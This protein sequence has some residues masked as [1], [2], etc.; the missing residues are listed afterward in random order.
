ME[1]LAAA[2]RAGDI[3]RLTVLLRELSDIDLGGELGS[4]LFREAAV[5]G[6]AEVVEELLLAGVDPNRAWP[7]RVEPVSWFAERGAWNM[8][9]TV[10]MHNHG[11]SSWPTVPESSLRAALALART[12]LTVDPEQELRRRL[13]A[14]DDPATV[15]ERERVPAWRDG[16]DGPSAVRI[17]VH[18]ADGRE[19]RV[20]VAHRAVVTLLEDAL[21]IVT[22]ND[23]IA[24]RAVHTAHPYSWD[25]A[26]AHT[27]IR[28]RAERDAAVF[29]WL[30]ARLTHPTVE[31]RR[32][33]AEVVQG[34][35]R[36]ERPFDDAQAADII[37]ARIR[38]ERDPV[39]LDNLIGAFAEFA[40]HARPGTDLRQILPHARHRDPL[41]RTRVAMELV[42][43]TGSRR[44]ET[45]PAPASSPPA[46]HIRTLIELAADPDPHTRATALGVLAGSYLDTTQ[47]RTV[48]IDHLSDPHAPARVPAA[49]GLS[50]RDDVRGQDALHLLRT[51]PVTADVACGWLADLDRILARRPAPQH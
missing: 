3:Q 39:V 42:L 29:D 35:C 36:R 41:V 23:E 2:V 1:R 48:F 13:G 19:D 20:W 43:V 28:E 21:G 17:R 7:G 9:V 26:Q 32:F 15:V 33:A 24:A 5:A 46:A 25:N 44:D 49:A 34:L 45:L 40:F 37:A 4:A 38:D 50:L 22:S 6:R 10:L 16:D 51:D 18:T 30:A 14:L 47:V 31:H 11:H 12:W 8:L 27:T